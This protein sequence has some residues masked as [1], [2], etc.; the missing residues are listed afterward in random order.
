MRVEIHTLRMLG[1]SS[2]NNGKDRLP[3]HCTYGGVRRTRVSA[4]AQRHV[5]RQAFRKS[6]ESS[7]PST[8]MLLGEL[9]GALKARKE[10]QP[11]N[12]VR[13]DL[14]ARK[15]LAFLKLE[16]DEHGVSRVQVR[17]AE[18]AF[19][20]LAEVV[21]T[22]R[23]TILTKEKVTKRLEWELANALFG[24]T[25]TELHVFGRYLAAFPDVEIFLCLDVASAVC[26]S[27]SPLE[28]NFFSS[29]DDIASKD[30]NSPYGIAHT[31]TNY[32]SS[33]NFYGFT[34]I[35][36]AQLCANH[37]KEGVEQIVKTL[38]DLVVYQFPKAKH[39]SSAPYAV[40]YLVTLAAGEGAC[41]HSALQAFDEPVRSSGGIRKRAVKR[42]H[43]HWERS[44]S[45]FA[46]ARYATLATA[47][48]IDIPENSVLNPMSYNNAKEEVMAWTTQ[49]LT[50]C[51]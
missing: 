11:P 3:K 26:V 14:L 35:D 18:G 16:A 38:I 25:N 51:S 34:S 49:S 46:P 31:N 29:I 33:P 13:I 43:E 7:A 44:H 8:R 40:P 5:I 45:T 10:L 48:L 12:G 9:R 36:L 30:P 6:L 41:S 2:V 42:F 19:A 47:S 1:P 23:E 24:P 21:A 17:Y 15:T 4:E 20:R 32:F 28:E 22:H 39:T 50:R 37:G 27:A